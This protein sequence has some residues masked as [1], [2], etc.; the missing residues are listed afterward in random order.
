MIALTLVKVAGVLSACPDPTAPPFM[1]ISLVRDPGLHMHGNLLPVQAVSSF[2]W[3]VD[4][5]MS[6]KLDW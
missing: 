3:A 5:L 2:V 4:L 1:L 6:D